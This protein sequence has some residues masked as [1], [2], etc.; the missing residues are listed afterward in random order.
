MKKAHQI[1]FPRR[2][3]SLFNNCDTWFSSHQ[4]FKPKK[5]G[6]LL[7]YIPSSW[8]IHL[9]FYTESRSPRR[10]ITAS[11]V[12]GKPIHGTAH[13]HGWVE[14]C[15]STDT[16]LIKQIPTWKVYS[17]CRT[18]LKVPGKVS[19]VSIYVVELVSRR[20]DCGKVVQLWR[21][22]EF[23]LFLLHTI[24][25]I[26]F[27]KYGKYSACVHD[28][29][30]HKQDIFNTVVVKRWSNSTVFSHYIFLMKMAWLQITLV[31]YYFPNKLFPWTVQS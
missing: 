3:F 8:Q 21:W 6:R 24:I 4:R 29:H 7:I 25:D 10:K 23:Q 15:Q 5:D 30:T 2:N 27:F 20:I 11:F 13:E 18:E 31:F 26:A 22:A 28:R 16:L 19:F 12:E 14:S 9:P 17:K 1:K